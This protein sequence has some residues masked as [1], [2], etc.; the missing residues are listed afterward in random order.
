MTVSPLLPEELALL[1]SMEHL[2]DFI[3][4]GRLKTIRIAQGFELLAAL[5]VDGRIV[6]AAERLSVNRRKVVGKPAN[7][8]P[9]DQCVGRL[10]G[11]PGLRQWGRPYGS[12][13]GRFGLLG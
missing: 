12:R 11:V 13:P 2:S 1:E 9:T 4:G 8:L 10:A 5:A 3:I 7:G 6:T